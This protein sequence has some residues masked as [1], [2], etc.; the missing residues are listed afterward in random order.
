M[1][2]A[3]IA[4]SHT[5][6]GQLLLKREITPASAI[7]HM[8]HRARSAQDHRAT[9]QIDLSPTNTTSRGEGGESQK[10]QIILRVDTTWSAPLAS[11]DLLNA[12]IAL[13]TDIPDVCPITST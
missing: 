9:T 5:G 11:N 4:G 7:V 10:F 2:L 8:L 3:G 6:G 1:P 13:S 12:D